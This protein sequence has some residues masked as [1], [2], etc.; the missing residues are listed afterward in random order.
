M[1]AF[2]T[3]AF[4]SHV[5]YHYEYFQLASFEHCLLVLLIIF[6]RHVFGIFMP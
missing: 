3:V 5:T 2:V 6:V 4:E 1:I